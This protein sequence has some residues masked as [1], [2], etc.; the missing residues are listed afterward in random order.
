MT[1]ALLAFILYHTMGHLLVQL[2]LSKIGPAAPQ[3]I[4]IFL[5]NK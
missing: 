2:K 1:G 3:T 4:Y 5:S